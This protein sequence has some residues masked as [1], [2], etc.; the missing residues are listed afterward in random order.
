MKSF[1]TFCNQIYLAT[2]SKIYYI[3]KRSSIVLLIRPFHR[4]L[5]MPDLLL[6][7]V[8]QVRCNLLILRSADIV[9]VDFYLVL[10]LPLHFDD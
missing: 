9:P 1:G 8:Y 10:R 3:S 7:F 6:I 4:L 2:N 5:S